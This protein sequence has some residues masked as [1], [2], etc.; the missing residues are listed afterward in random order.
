MKKEQLQIFATILENE[1]FKKRKSFCHHGDITVYEHSLKVALMAYKISRFFKNIDLNSLIIGAL[2]HDFYFRDWQSYREKR[3]F[4][5]KHGFVHAKEAL[6]N[7]EIHF[8]MLMND[9]VRNIILR[10]MFPLN[11]I[12]PRYKEAWIVSIADKL[13]SLETLLQPKFFL[14]LFGL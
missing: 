1:E 10:H 9:R 13:V 8:P 6:D 2:L 3:P 5:K 11:K 12:P 7:S 4:F 14:R